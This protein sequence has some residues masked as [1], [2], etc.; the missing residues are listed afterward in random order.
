MPVVT[1]QIE[2]GARVFLFTCET[3]GAS[4]AF[5][6]GASLR[7]A[8]ER[9]DVTLTGRWYCHQH[10]PELTESKPQPA[11]D[12][13]RETESTDARDGRGEA[14]GDLFGD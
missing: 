14:T 9:R 6:Y 5:G 7:L 8:I 2:G 11:H 4:A 13:P 12:A 3:C 1:H 10:R